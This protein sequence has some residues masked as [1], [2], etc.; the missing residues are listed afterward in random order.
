MRIK[1]GFVAR[2]IMGVTVVVAVGER[3]ERFKGMVRLNH[4][5]AVIWRGICN[6][7]SEEEIARKLVNTYSEVDHEKALS[8]T[9]R[10]IRRLAEEGIVEL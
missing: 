9:R 8:D 6:G 7:M 2:E 10:T 3:A 4:S 5:G 1:D